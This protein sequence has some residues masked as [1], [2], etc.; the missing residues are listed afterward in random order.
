MAS[1]SYQ[2]MSTDPIVPDQPAFAVPSAGYNP[3]GQY[4]AVIT[5]PQ[6]R[7]IQVI[8]PMTGGPTVVVTQPVVNVPEPQT[9]CALI[10]SVLSSIFCCFVCGIMGILVSWRARL[11]VLDN[12]LEHARHSV[13]IVWIL[14]AFTI[15][16]GII[17]WIVVAVYVAI[18]TKYLF[19]SYYCSSSGCYYRC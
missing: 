19:C 16:F 2:Q 9:Q 5:A 4:G 7:E 11:Y 18:G 10:M 15:I 17:T 14:F 13:N 6:Q 3:G 1:A 12:K 8:H